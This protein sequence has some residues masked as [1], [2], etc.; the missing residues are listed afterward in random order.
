MEVY[1]K[2]TCSIP[3][4]KGKYI[5]VQTSCEITGE[6]LIKTSDK[7]V[8]RLVLLDIVYNLKGN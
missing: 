8:P 3:T 1:A 4:E 5:P 2:D 6:V 7:N